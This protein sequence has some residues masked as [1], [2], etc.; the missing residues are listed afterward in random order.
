[1]AK[2]GHLNVQSRSILVGLIASL[3]VERVK[4]TSIKDGVS[5]SPIPVLQRANR[6]L[7]NISVLEIPKL[8]KR[9][10][11]VPNSCNR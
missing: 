9:N 1:M 11:K 10:R 7:K 4:I 2:M 3:M 6:H 5:F 8:I